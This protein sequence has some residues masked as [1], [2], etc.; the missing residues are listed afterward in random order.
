MATDRRFSHPQAS[1]EF[2]QRP[3]RKPFHVVVSCRDGGRQEHAPQKQVK[4]EMSVDLANAHD[5]QLC[6]APTGHGER[7]ADDPTASCQGEDVSLRHGS[8]EKETPRA[9]GSENCFES[10][11]V[12]W[13]S[14]AASRTMPT[15]NRGRISA[16]LTQRNCTNRHQGSTMER[17]KFH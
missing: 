15:A 17:R 10:V 11:P 13:R 3:R 9:R 4:D 14:G 12:E 1:H 8:E 7:S 2:A 6:G 5:H 16:R